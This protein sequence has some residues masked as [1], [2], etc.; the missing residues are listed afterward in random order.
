M[1]DGLIWWQESRSHNVPWEWQHLVCICLDEQG[2]AWDEY[3]SDGNATAAAV[4]TCRSCGKLKRFY[5]SRCSNCHEVYLMVF[6]CK[7]WKP[8]INRCYSCMLALHGNNEHDATCRAPNVKYTVPRVHATDSEID[9]ALDF[10]DDTPDIS[11][12]L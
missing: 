6:F 3:T 12:D 7:E 5:N 11:F 2:E 1:G 9:A 10:F 4:R 8:Y